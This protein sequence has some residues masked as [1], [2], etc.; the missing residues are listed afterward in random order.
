MTTAGRLLDH[1]KA[2]AEAEAR[3]KIAERETFQHAN[4]GLSGLYLSKFIRARE[5]LERLRDTDIDYL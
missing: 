4:D 5:E 1:L 3:F 2:I